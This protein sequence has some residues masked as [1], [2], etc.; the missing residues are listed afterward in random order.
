[1]ETIAAVVKI[2]V[3]ESRLDTHMEMVITMK[4]KFWPR[5]ATSATATASSTALIRTSGLIM[6]TMVIGST[7]CVKE[8]VTVTT[9]MRT[10]TWGL[11][12]PTNAMAKVNFSH[13][14]KTDIKVSGGMICVMVRETRHLKMGLR[15]LELGAKT[16][17]MVRER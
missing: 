9:I 3:V 17:S 8:R 2:M 4:A 12:R 13:A 6:S 16:R 11:G 7:T 15:T 5:G 10:Y 14:N 1:M